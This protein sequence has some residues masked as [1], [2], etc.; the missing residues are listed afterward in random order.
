M[1]SMSLQGYDLAASR[2]IFAECGAKALLRKAEE[3]LVGYE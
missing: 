2:A 3:L 1:H